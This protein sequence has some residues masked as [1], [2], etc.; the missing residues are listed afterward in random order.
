ML[1]NLSKSQ[2]ESEHQGFEPQKEDSL[3]GYDRQFPT[4]SRTMENE[5]RITLSISP[6]GR[7]LL[8]PPHAFF[9]AGLSLDLPQLLCSPL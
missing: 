7:Q 2:R 4:H 5:V 8:H 6:L 9:N 3:Q 1:S